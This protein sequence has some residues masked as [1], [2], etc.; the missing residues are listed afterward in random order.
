MKFQ[1]H[2]VH[3]TREILSSAKMAYSTY[4]QRLDQKKEEKEMQLKKQEEAKSVK[5]RQD[6]EREEEVTRSTLVL[7]KEKELL[8]KESEL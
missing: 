7:D 5:K 3:L 1:P 2:K 6:R 4:R 8:K